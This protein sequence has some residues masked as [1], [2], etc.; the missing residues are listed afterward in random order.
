ALH[1]EKT[2]WLAMAAHDLRNPLSS[3]LACCEAL[4]GDSTSKDSEHT[5]MLQSI[6]SCGQ[7]MLELLGDVQD[8]SVTATG[9]QP[10][11][12]EPTDV[13]SLI[14]EAIAF[15]RPI[16]D[17]K[18]TRIEARY[19][20]SILPVT[21]D[22]RKMTQ[23]FL[24]LVGN[25]I[26]FCGNGSSVYVTVVDEPTNVLISVQDNGPGIPRDEL[27]SI[28]MPFQRG[29]SSVAAQ[30]GTGL[31]LAICKRIV[32]RHDGQIWADNAIDGGAVFFL[33]LPR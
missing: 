12:A 27:G 22:R 32:E 6:Q 15:S 17:R 11:L 7:F 30:P 33:S 29:R 2:Q 14:E 3:I 13:R 10:F 9:G 31:G 4:M 16:A 8:L 23:V 1:K 28:F 21:L 5:A 24:N 25:A 20:E 19:G 26:K 18:N